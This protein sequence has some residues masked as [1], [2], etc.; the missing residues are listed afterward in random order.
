MTDSTELAEV[1]SILKACD[2]CG[3]DHRTKFSDDL[4]QPLSNLT[5]RTML[6]RAGQLL[7][8]IASAFDHAGQPIQATLGFFSMPFFKSVQS[9]LLKLF[10]LFRRTSHPDLGPP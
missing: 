8:H 5:Q 9:I 4:A 6:H 10:L 7:A 2:F 1:S 3:L